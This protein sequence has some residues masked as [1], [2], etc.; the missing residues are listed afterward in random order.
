MRG[1]LVTNR[2]T[3]AF[4]FHASHHQKEKKFTECISYQTKNNTTQ[5]N[6]R[7]RAGPSLM[8]VRQLPKALFLPQNFR[9]EPKKNKNFDKSD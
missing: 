9:K 5:P 4:I 2:K 3:H 6:N 7:N 8:R 1:K